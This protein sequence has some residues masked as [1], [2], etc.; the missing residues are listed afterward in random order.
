MESENS[1]LVS[2]LLAVSENLYLKRA[3]PGSMYGAVF[4]QAQLAGY[5]PSS[6]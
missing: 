4:S 1:S 2:F 5:L 3:C 6:T